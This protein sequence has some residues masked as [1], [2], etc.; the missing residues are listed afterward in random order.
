MDEPEKVQLVYDPDEPTNWKAQLGEL[1]A[2]L[3]LPDERRL[4]AFRVG[5][6]KPPFLTDIF[7]PAEYSKAL[8]SNILI[9]VFPHAVASD[10]PSELDRF[11]A[12]LVEQDKNMLSFSAIVLR[13]SKWQVDV[14]G[15]D[16]LAKVEKAKTLLRKRNYD[17]YKLESLVEEEE[18]EVKVLFQGEASF[19][20][21]VVGSDNFIFL[22]ML[23]LFYNV[24]QKAQ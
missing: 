5:T 18:R 22:I 13:T 24:Q 1:S 19:C 17:P 11:I 14:E 4:F 3:N 23:M 20:R 12:R 15:L 6:T 16:A 2:D 7:D 10:D 21:A 8:F 9:D